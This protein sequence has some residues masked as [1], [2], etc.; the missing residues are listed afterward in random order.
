MNP[1]LLLSG[2]LMAGGLWITQSA[3]AAPTSHVL[4][5]A[6]YSIR[7]KA[8]VAAGQGIDR[9]SDTILTKNPLKM[10]SAAS[11]I[12]SG[13]ENGCYL[14]VRP[15]NDWPLTAAV[16]CAAN[17]D[18]TMGWEFVKYASLD[19]LGDQ[20]ST[21]IAGCDHCELALTNQG[22]STWQSTTANDSSSNDSIV[23]KS[24]LL[25]VPKTGST[26]GKGSKLL[27]AKGL[28]YFQGNQ[29]LIYGG[30]SGGLSQIKWIDGATIP[31]ALQACAD[32][33]VAEKTNAGSGTVEY[34]R[35]N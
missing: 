30:T 5:N 21:S 14:N 12:K 1:K 28:V 29:S 3:F 17:H 8:S 20:S 25:L 4:D 31:T 16:Y 13:H 24:T 22:K 35:F 18:G 9:S 32:S 10:D 11:S 7:L 26:N 27:N 2:L 33:W 19:L 6:W 34:C 23:L 15:D